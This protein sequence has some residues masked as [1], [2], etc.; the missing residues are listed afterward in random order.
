MILHKAEDAWK[1]VNQFGTSKLRELIQVDTN[2]Q[3]NNLTKSDDSA[4]DLSVVIEA[5]N[6]INK[7]LDIY[8]LSRKFNKTSYCLSVEVSSS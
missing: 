5:T 2:S 8:F 4:S 6:N 3:E 7:T 1:V